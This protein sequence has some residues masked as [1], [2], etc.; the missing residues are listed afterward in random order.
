MGQQQATQAATPQPPADQQ[1]GKPVFFVRPSLAF[2]HVLV[3]KEFF[4]I[5]HGD[6]TPLLG[7]PMSRGC[8]PS[9]DMRARRS[10]SA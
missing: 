3:F 6:H 4:D 1:S 5:C 2:A 10:F 9:R 8:C 7:Q